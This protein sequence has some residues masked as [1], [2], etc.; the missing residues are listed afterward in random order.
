MRAY[1]KGKAVCV[2]CKLSGEENPRIAKD[3]LCNSC[4]RL[5]ELGK[6]VKENSDGYS[7]IQL[8]RWNIHHAALKKED[9]PDKFNFYQGTGNPY[10]VGNDISGNLCIT[11]NNL[12]KT[13]DAGEKDKIEYRVF[14]KE[15]GETIF[16]KTETALAYYEFIKS[17][18]IYS[19]AIAE[20]EFKRGKQLLIGLNNGTLTLKDF[21]ER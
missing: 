21:E 8:G 5:L 1:Y 17:L 16:V 10:Y 9:R 18:V 19:R 6:G 3:E 7:I 2:G 12:M 13:I 11:F 20:T 14:M 4:K 15:H